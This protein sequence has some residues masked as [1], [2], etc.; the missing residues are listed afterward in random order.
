MTGEGGLFDP[1]TPIFFNFERGGSRC[2]SGRWWI[3]TTHNNNQQQK[4]LKPVDRAHRKRVR[5]DLWEASQYWL[6][7]QPL[8]GENGVRPGG[9]RKQ[10]TG[11]YL[12]CFGLYCQTTATQQS[13]IDRMR[14]GR[15][16]GWLDMGREGLFRPRAPVFIKFERL[17]IVCQAGEMLNIFCS[18]EVD[19]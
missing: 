4:R 17:K 10:D 6:N 13:S 7:N 5:Y 1:Q 2:R 8:S 9:G 12:F 11:Q 15:V 3:A 16:F 18:N 14:P 19:Q